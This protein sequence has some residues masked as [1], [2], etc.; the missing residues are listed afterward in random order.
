MWTRL[1]SKRALTHT[2]AAVSRQWNLPT[3]ATT[4]LRPMIGRTLSTTNVNR[5]EVTFG[6]F[7]SAQTLKDQETVYYNA[8]D[9]FA[10]TAEVSEL[11]QGAVPPVE[12]VL[13]NCAANPAEAACYNSAGAVWAH[14]FFFQGLTQE[15]NAQ[16]PSEGI[17]K[18]LEECGDWESVHAFKE[19]LIAKAAS[20]QGNGWVWLVKETLLHDE[21][22]TTGEDDVDVRGLEIRLVVTKDNDTPLKTFGVQVPLLAL[23]MWEH[24]YIKDYGVGNFVDYVENF[25][26]HIDWEVVEDRFTDSESL[27]IQHEL[28]NDDGTPI[29]LFDEAE[30]IEA[31]EEEEIEAAE[32]DSDDV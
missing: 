4:T 22:T 1:A 16:P 11:F 10:E 25:V 6:E 30:E 31:E 32:E 18:V 7:I 28:F 15:A 24:A 2:F 8:A 12:L 29:G 5:N 3:T 23:D 14:R 27:M 20:V 26:Q 13:T 21:Y 17:L 9:S 19:D